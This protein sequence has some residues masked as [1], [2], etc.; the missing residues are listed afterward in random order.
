MKNFAPLKIL[1]IIL[2]ELSKLTLV[3]IMTFFVFLLVN[4]ILH[5]QIHVCPW[6]LS[7]FNRNDIV[8][9]TYGYATD[10]SFEKS[11]QGKVVLGGCVTGPVAGVCPF[12]HWPAAITRNMPDEVTLD[13]KTLAGL[14]TSGRDNL[15]HFMV[16][17]LKQA[18]GDE[19]VT[20]VCI[21]SND[22]WI[23][24]VNSG[25]QRMDRRTGM[26]ESYRDGTIG[27]C[28][29]KIKSDQ[30]R[31]FVEHIHSGLGRMWVR[32]ASADRGKS[33]ERL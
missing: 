11:K 29:F 12:C 24:T 17:V 7:G 13:D 8:P 21:T 3:M 33:W 18:R 25:L 32:D 28:I 2:S 20:A 31:I 22:V 10:E 30:D 1:L 19:M 6:H 5:V 23:G 9:V 26:G 4:T 16:S 14:S 27:D 15:N